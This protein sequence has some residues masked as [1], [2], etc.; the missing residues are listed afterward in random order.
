GSGAHFPVREKTLLVYRHFP[1]SSGKPR[2][3]NR[4]AY[5]GSSQATEQRRVAAMR[6]PILNPVFVEARMLKGVGPKVEKLIGK[7][8]GIEA[9]PPRILDLIF[10]LPFS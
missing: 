10:H 1:A 4:A 6:P 8:L 2:G 7:A 5:R 3:S 9:R